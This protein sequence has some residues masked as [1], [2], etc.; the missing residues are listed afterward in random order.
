MDLAVFSQGKTQVWA[1]KRLMRS[2]DQ[3][4]ASEALR[5]FRLPTFPRGCW[6]HICMLPSTTYTHTVSHCN[7]NSS[8]AGRPSSSPL[9]GWLN[10]CRVE[11]GPECWLWLAC[12]LS[13]SWGEGSSPATAQCQNRPPRAAIRHK[14]T[15]THRVTGYTRMHVCRVNV[16]E[17]DEWKFMYETCTWRKRH[18]LKQ[19]DR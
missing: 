17:W 7:C 2:A 9:S 10:G 11:R 8:A 15:R 18:K 6:G 16:H 5:K 13:I 12:L 14:V 4:V 19:K 1:Q 3:D